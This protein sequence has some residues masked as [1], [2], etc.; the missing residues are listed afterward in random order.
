MPDV[1]LQHLI[2]L[3]LVDGGVTFASSH[4]FS[5]MKD[6]DILAVRK[7]IEA[8]PSPELTRAKPARQAIIEV[9]MVERQIFSAP[10]ARRTRHTC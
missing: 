8:I 4:D 7:R 2:A 1:C 6:P 10:H 9:D 5:R 3:A